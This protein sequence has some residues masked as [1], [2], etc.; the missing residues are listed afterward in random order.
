MAIDR[1]RLYEL[2]WERMTEEATDVLSLGWEGGSAGNSGAVWLKEWHGIYFTQSSDFDPS[3]PFDSIDEALSE[4]CFNTEG[5]PNAELCCGVL[6]LKELRRIA[7]RVGTEG[8]IIRINDQP[9]MLKAGKLRA[10]R[11]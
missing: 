9:F 3:G 1:D 11:D 10:T 5:T 8:E 6:K 4:E 2:L 7:V